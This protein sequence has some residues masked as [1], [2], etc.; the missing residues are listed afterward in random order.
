MRCLLRRLASRRFLSTA[1]R[2]NGLVLPSHLKQSPFITPTPP[3]RCMA[4]ANPFWAYPIA[5]VGD[6][7]VAS[8]QIAP[9][10]AAIRAAPQRTLRI[11]THEDENG[12]V[13]NASFFDDEPTMKAFFEWYYINALHPDGEFHHCL[14]PAAAEENELPTKDTLLFASGTRIL[15]DTRFGEYQLGMAVRYSAW[16]PWSADMFEEAAVGAARD[17]FEERIAESMNARGVAYFGR[18]V[19]AEEATEGSPGRIVTAVRFGSLDDARRGSALTR[20]LV[21]SELSRWF[22]PSPLTIYGTAL[23]V[24]EV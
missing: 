21:H 8:S 1:P 5:V 18:L 14:T 7:G 9:L 15:A 2:L 20:E 4:V 13:F 11:I 6:G 3:G 17:E 24:L 16:V 22:Q 12:R 23:R 19:L 10:I